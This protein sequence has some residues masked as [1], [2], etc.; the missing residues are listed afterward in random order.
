MWLKFVVLEF[1]SSVMNTSSPIER[2]KGSIP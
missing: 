1:Y 2:V